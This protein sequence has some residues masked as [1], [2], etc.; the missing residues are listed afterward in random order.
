[1]EGFPSVFFSL[2]SPLEWFL[3]RT[4]G[5]SIFFSR[6]ARSFFPDE[7]TGYIG[8]LTLPPKLFSSQNFGGFSPPFSFW[9]SGFP[10]TFGPL[11]LSPPFVPKNLVPPLMAFGLTDFLFS[12]PPPQWLGRFVCFLVSF[13]GNVFLPRTFPAALPFFF[14]VGVIPLPGRNP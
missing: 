9:G 10:R 12:F 14:S 8:P 3:G 5:S 2:S 1:M 13:P 7:T 11:I 6:L 4:A